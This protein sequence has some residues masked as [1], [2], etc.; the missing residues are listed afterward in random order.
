M[1]RARVVSVGKRVP[2]ALPPRNPGRVASPTS[3]SQT[4]VDGFDKVS[5]N[6][7]SEEKHDGDHVVSPIS[8]RDDVQDPGFHS[9]PV[10]P[11]E[12]S[13]EKSNDIPGS[14]Q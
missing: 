11:N 2:P 6:G 13:K 4:P 9:I 14:F 1:A 3:E 7:A 5:L 12:E 10:T 8:T